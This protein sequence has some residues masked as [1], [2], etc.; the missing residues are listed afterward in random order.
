MKF[1]LTYRFS[2]LD[3]FSIILVVN[4]SDH[5]WPLA[6]IV[7]LCLAALTVFLEREYQI[8]RF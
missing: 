5:G 8:R 6:L 3:I 1:L 2:W 4:V 7:G